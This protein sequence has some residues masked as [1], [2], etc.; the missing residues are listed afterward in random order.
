MS[1]LRNPSSLEELLKE[2]IEYASEDKKHFYVRIVDPTAYVSNTVSSDNSIYVVDKKTG[3]V[4][5]EYASSYLLFIEPKAKRLTD[6]YKQLKLS[7]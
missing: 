7:K 3:T 6:P 1:A 5:L 2:K 4:S